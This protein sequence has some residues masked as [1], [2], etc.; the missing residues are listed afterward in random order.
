MEIISS[1]PV[2]IVKLHSFYIAKN[3]KLSYEI[4]HGTIRLCSYEEYIERLVYFVSHLRPDIV[5][6]RLFSR[7]PEKDS[8]FSNWGKSWWVL[9]DLWK[10]E[11]QRQNLYQGKLYIP[12]NESAYINGAGN[13][14]FFT[15]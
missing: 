2:Q 3:T 15:Y 1:Q 12:A 6:E 7:I 14:S 9:M 8:V 13:G 5:I 11:M 10:E 4:E